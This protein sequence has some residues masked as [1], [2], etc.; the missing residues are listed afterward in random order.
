MVAVRERPTYKAR[1]VRS[2]A[3]WA[4]SVAEVPGAHT[5]ARRL[6]QA[7]AIA[8]EAIALVLN[9]PPD[10]FDVE[11]A[12]ELAEELQAAIA[13]MGQRKQ[14]AADAQRSATD[15]AAAT[16]RALLDAGLTVRD[17]GRMLGLSYQRVAQLV[18]HGPEALSVKASSG[19]S[20]VVSAGTGPPVGSASGRSRKTGSPRS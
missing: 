8:R 11:L 17:A 2:G 10:S 4:I 1:C 6:E 13:S 5:Q 15:A 19:R 16:A 12:P 20:T 14:E 9:V 3:W 7:E 18:G